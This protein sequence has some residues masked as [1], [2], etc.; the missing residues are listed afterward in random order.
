MENP[1]NEM[2]EKQISNKIQDVK[3]RIEKMMVILED[4]KIEAREI[5]L[6]IHNVEEYLLL[7]EFRN[8]KKKQMT[9]TIQNF[10]TPKQGTFGGK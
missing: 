10:M 7:I 6:V 9:E 8:L 3:Q 5:D 1:R 4:E 2:N